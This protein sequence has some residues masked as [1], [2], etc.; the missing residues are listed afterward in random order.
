MEAEDGRV[1]F[2]GSLPPE[3]AIVVLG[4]CT[5]IEIA[6]ICRVCQSWKLCVGND[7][8]LS[9]SPS[10]THRIADQELTWKCTVQKRLAFE[11]VELPKDYP[12]WREYSRYTHQLPLPITITV[13]IGDAHYGVHKRIPCF[14][15]CLFKAICVCR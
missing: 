11:E 6:Q 4:H 7:Y 13:L 14:Y 12:T 9:D 8:N 3:V 15:F 2:L 10:S 1:D 5:V